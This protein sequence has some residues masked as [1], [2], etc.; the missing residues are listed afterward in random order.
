MTPGRA[1]TALA[2]AREAAFQALRAIAAQELDLGEALSRSRD[3]LDDPR[4]RALATDLVTG[5]LRW[6]GAIDYQLARLSSKPL[7]RLDAPVVDALRLGAYQLLH[8]HRVPVRAAVN[9]S[10]ELVK[11]ARLTSAA[12]F[13]NGVLR[14]LARER[15][16]LVWP[17]RPTSMTTG[18]DRLELSHH[19][20]VVHS[21]PQWLVERW[22]ERYGADVT[23]TWL[24]FN[25]QP[26]RITLAANRLRLDRDTLA[27]RLRDDGFASH[28]TPIAPAGLLFDDSR[29]LASAALRD[30]DAVVQDEAS[31]IIPELVQAA[32]GARVF[33][34]CA[35]PGGKT[36]AL[37]AQVGPAGLVVAA[38]VRPRRVRLLAS[39]IARTGASRVRVA[40]VPDR[41]AL[42]FAETVFDRVLVDAPCSGLGT[43]RRDPDI[44]WRR[45]PDDLPRLAAAQLELLRRI[46]PHVGLGGRLIY[47][48]CSSEPEE[49]EDVVSSFLR[50][51]PDFTLEPLRDVA[52][53]P[54][55]VTALA[56]PAGHLRT[57]PAQGLEAFFGAV[58]RRT[59]RDSGVR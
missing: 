48:T 55:A 7:E 32:P 17:Q 9:D 58:L 34:A 19:F 2:P 10:V 42:P 26:A 45:M 54:P 44:R 6:R 14:R 46:A 13:V 25:N 28:I 51:H 37:A 31:Q 5:T 11:R 38:D 15:D 59:P 50:S 36:L 8:L 24:Q 40:H 21:H 52:G 16:A 3:P 20:A 41:G 29:V 23:E 57:T 47:S 39:T 30:G 27:A 4:D 18:G 43:V 56:T 49:N 12:A 35:A 22:L 53:L 1:R 33:D